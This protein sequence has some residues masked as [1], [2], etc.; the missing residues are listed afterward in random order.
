MIPKYI[1]TELLAHAES[2][3]PREACGIIVKVEGGKR[4]IPCKNIKPESERKEDGPEFGFIIDPAGYAEAEDAG[5]IYA[6]F[7]SH[8]DS[9]AQPSQVDLLQCDEG[10]VDWVISSW[11]DG[12][13]YQ[14]SPRKKERPYEDRHFVLGVSDCWTIIADFYQR[15]YGMTLT[16]YSVPDQW[17]ND[18]KNLYMDNWQKE[19]FIDIGDAEPVRGDV[20]IMQVRADVPNHGGVYLGDGKMLHHM[21][22][23]KSKI[24]NYDE[25][26]RTSTKLIVRHKDEPQA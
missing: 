25:Y 26:Y 13:I 15:E 7:H 24:V 2:E 12:E 17:W 4:Y 10:A 8:P 1:K 14:F 3:Y 11:P 22:G 19:G 6:I 9:G 23:R 16:N 20:I 21:F 5:E 18:G